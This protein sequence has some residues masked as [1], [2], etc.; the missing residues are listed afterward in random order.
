[1]ALEERLQLLRRRRPGKR[2]PA[3]AQSQTEQVHHDRLAGQLDHRLAPV[4]LRLLA[5]RR[6][7]RDH[8]LAQAQ[9]L[10]RPQPR[11]V[12]PH[13]RLPARERVLG[14]EPVIDPLGGMALLGRRLGVVDQPALDH[15]PVGIHGRTR[16]R[17]AQVVPRWLRARQR[18]AHRLACDPELPAEPPDRPTVHEVLL[19]DELDLDH[20]EHVP[21]PLPPRSALAAYRAAT[22]QVVNLS[23]SATPSGG[24][25]LA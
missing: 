21:F 17:L 25:H 18:L 9:P 19:P 8:H 5:P 12:P 10:R 16:P 14:D 15:R 4:D 22:R 23:V 20:L 2:H 11:H 1:M 13:R 24:Q 6:R 7:Q 3:R